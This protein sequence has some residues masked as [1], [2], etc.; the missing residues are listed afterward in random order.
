MKFPR[1]K[2]LWLPKWYPN[3]YDIL[4]GIFTVEHAT[5]AAIH[6][7]I[8]VLFVHSDGDQ[9]ERT[10]EEYQ[11][12]EGYHE[13]SVYFR[14]RKVGV[15]AIDAFLIG[16][17]YLRTQFKA[18]RK[19]RKDWGRPDA[20]HIHTLAR[21]SGLALWLKWTRKIPFFVTEHWSG[22]DPDTHYKIGWVKKRFIGLILK[23]ATCTT[24]VSQYLQNHVSPFAPSANYSVISNTVD[25][26]K[27]RPQEKRSSAKKKIIHIST[28]DDY[29][30]N[31]GNILR[32]IAELSKVA[33]EFELNVF[34]V[35]VE[36]EKQEQLA[37]DLGV[38]NTHV[39]FK[40]YRD[41]ESLATEIATSDF[42]ILF[43]LHETQSC[44]VIEAL[45]C[46]I[47]VIV[48][49]LGGVQE[50][51]SAANGIAVP[52][53]SNDAFHHAILTLL[54]GDKTFD[55]GKIRTNALQ[56]SHASIGQQFADIYATI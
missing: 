3:R 30:K 5:A 25:A 27:F 35:G 37:K 41:K 15:K 20:T 39:F 56:F 24:T 12:T 26:N 38:Y 14:H 23:N 40:G 36:K 46:G 33:P 45:L 55:S 28:L 43:S 54:R 10:R 53:M 21:T 17:K 6:N 52:P 44:V 47:P 49:Q 4:D 11:F 19:I 31:F 18:Y 29:P 22:F 32:V 1:K 48:P 51:V 13:L 8:Y 9:K 50:L 34:G 2:V 16:I 7:D 42:M